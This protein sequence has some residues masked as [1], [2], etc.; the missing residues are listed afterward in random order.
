MASFSARSIFTY[1]D[2]RDAF[3]RYLATERRLSPLTVKGYCADLGFFVDFAVSKLGDFDPAKVKK[4]LVRSYLKS[5]YDE[6]LSPATIGRRLAAVRAYFRF[7]VRTGVLE[8]NPADAVRTP[9]LDKR[10]PRFLSADDA[11]RL[12]EAPKGDEA[13]AVRDRAILELCYSSGLRVS[14]VSNLDLGDVDLAQKLVRVLGK[15]NKTRLVPIGSYALAALRA[16]LPRRPELCGK[17]EHATALFRSSRGGRMG[18]RAIQRLVE[19]SRLSCQQ[20]G[21]TPHWLRH[22][23][24]THMLA[25]GADLRSIQELLGHSSLSTTQKYTHIQVEMLMQTYDKAHPRAHLAEEST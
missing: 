11:A 19:Q 8:Q 23:C 14:E 16:Y 24:A 6:S 12:V 13:T 20:A 9:K 10:T 21:A 3:Q 15:G 25:S 18:P 2:T 1:M 5:L 7:L 17:E 4:L 22:A